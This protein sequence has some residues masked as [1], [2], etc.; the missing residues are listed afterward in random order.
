[1]KSLEACTSVYQIDEFYLRDFWHC[2]Q[3]LTSHIQ[4]F[5][6]Q[7]PLNVSWKIKYVLLTS[8]Q[9]ITVLSTEAKLD[10]TED[11]VTHSYCVTHNHQ[12]DNK[13]PLHLLSPF[14]EAVNFAAISSIRRLV[15]SFFGARLHYK[16][17]AKPLSIH[18]CTL[19]VKVRITQD[20][21]NHIVQIGPYLSLSFCCVYT[22]VFP[23][24]WAEYWLSERASLGCCA[25]ILYNREGRRKKG[26]SGPS[27]F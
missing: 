19:L 18:T 26:T 8:H 3:Q 2:F 24:E 9:S 15:R 4:L 10:T 13:I 22:A 12:N 27:Y 1:M 5:F 23:S 11:T 16:C 17:V 6:A 7:I 21:T 25:V 14:S 20:Q